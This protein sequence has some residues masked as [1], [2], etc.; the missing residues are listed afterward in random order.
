MPEL[1]PFK[2]ELLIEQDIDELYLSPLFKNQ[3]EDLHTLSLGLKFD[4]D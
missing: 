2:K 4:L 3:L 1:A